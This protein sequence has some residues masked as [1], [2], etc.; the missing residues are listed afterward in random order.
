MSK[1]IYDSIFPPS[2]RKMLEM[3]ERLSQHLAPTERLAHLHS[4]PDMSSL[5]INDSM[6]E[7]IKEFNSINPYLDDYNS[8][9]SAIE[10]FKMYNELHKYPY[11][12]GVSNN[13]NSSVSK[14]F[15]NLAK[16]SDIQRHDLSANDLV[17]WIN[18][19]KK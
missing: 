14:T 13:L 1:D 12:I 3:Q 9:Y 11:D 6:L 4:L 16:L 15:E 7:K 17:K 10:N 18:Q 19:V 8:R 5:Y 2:V